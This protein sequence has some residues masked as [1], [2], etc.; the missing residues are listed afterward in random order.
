MNPEQASKVKSRMPIHQRTGE[1]RRASI[2]TEVFDAIRRGN[3]N[4][5]YARLH[6]ERGRSR[7]VGGGVVIV[8]SEHCH[9]AVAGRE[10]G[11][12]RSS[13]G[14][15]APS[16]EAANPGGAKGPCFWF[17]CLREPKVERRLAR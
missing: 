8:A 13:D 3:G 10:V 14:E 5:T 2:R 12:A 7:S 15:A 11:K 4:G 1:G 16:R 9:R 17:A 6:T